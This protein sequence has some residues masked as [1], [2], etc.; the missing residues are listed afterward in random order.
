ME[1][2]EEGSEEGIRGV[3]R[4]GLSLR[5]MG[6]GTTTGGSS[7]RCHPF[8]LPIPNIL[9]QTSPMK[10]LTATIFLTIAVK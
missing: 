4:V 1:Y 7:T 2:P 3:C 10:N 6:S 9:C 8:S 5:G